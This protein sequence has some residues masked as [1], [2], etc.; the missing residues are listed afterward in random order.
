MK[1]KAKITAV[2]ISIILMFCG[3]E[4]SA[5]HQDESTTSQP[6]SSYSATV[7]V[8]SV[9]I[10]SSAEFD[11]EVIP[12]FNNSPYV[13]INN[14]IPDFTEEDYTISSFESYGELDN[15]GRC[16]VSYACIGQDLMPTEERGE[17]GSVKPTGWHTVKYDC[18]D[19]KYLYNRCHL[20]GY[21]LTAENANVKNLI[22]GTRYL[23]VEGMLPFENLVNDYIDSTGNHVLYRVTPRFKGSELIARGVQI[24]GYSVE[25]KGEGVCFNVYCYNNQP[26]ITID[27]AT[28]ESH[29]T[30]EST[31]VKDDGTAG[32]YIVNTK[33]K[34]FHKPDC[35]AVD[36]MNDNNKK[37]YT[38]SRSSLI[39]NGYE[40][41]KQCNP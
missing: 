28:G 8:S 32:T 37:K 30:S 16:T 31:T 35:S 25:D 5:L 33:S 40:P 12:E 29:L 24:E 10:D 36:S 34:K 13:V 21:Q 6:T 1:I 18:V 19:G 27:Y 23:N 7:D 26:E 22:T 2:I 14:N 38:G 15:L 39:N 4:A 9:T 41:C 3:C 11:F 20:I 17:I